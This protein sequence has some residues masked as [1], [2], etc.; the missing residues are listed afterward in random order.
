M[1]KSGPCLFNKATNLFFH[2]SEQRGDMLVGGYNSWT[3]CTIDWSLG[4]PSML[5]TLSSKGSQ[6]AFCVASA[7]RISYPSSDPPYDVES[8]RFDGCAR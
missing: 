1:L 2:G 5:S 8:W 7:Y 4:Q 3:I 6:N